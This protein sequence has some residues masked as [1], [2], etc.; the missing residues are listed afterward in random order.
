M[1]KASSCWTLLR[2]LSWCKTMQMQLKIAYPQIFTTR[3]SNQLQLRQ[4]PVWSCS[5]FTRMRWYQGSSPNNGL[6]AKCPIHHG[7]RSLSTLMPRQNGRQFAD[8]IFKCLFLSENVYISIKTSLK[9]VPKGPIDNMT[10]LVQI[11]AWRRTGDKPISEPMTVSLMMH[12]CVTRP[13]WVK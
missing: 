8:G 11:M 2:S 12:I 6:Q 4:I 7:F 1:Q 13:Q 5:D 3:S 10:A 9:F